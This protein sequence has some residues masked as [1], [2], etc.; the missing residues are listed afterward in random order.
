M[1]VAEWRPWEFIPFSYGPLSI[2]SV[3]SIG[4]QFCLGPCGKGA[5]AGGRPGSRVEVGATLL[6]TFGATGPLR[7]Q[8]CSKP[9]RS[10][11]SRPPP[12]SPRANQIE[13]SSHFV[14]N[15]RSPWTEGGVCGCDDALG[16]GQ[17]QPLNKS[18]TGPTSLPNM[19]NLRIFTQSRGDSVITFDDRSSRDREPERVASLQLHH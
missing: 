16:I 3:G 1:R 5:L 10:L 6:G 2:R 14:G 15:D 18:E 17:R 13:G 4:C 12:K 9:G 19:R 7:R 11:A 8:G